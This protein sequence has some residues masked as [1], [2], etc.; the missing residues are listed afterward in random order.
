MPPGSVYLYVVNTS[1]T[2]VPDAP[3]NLVATAG[4]GKITLNW[5]A[6]AG[7]T[8]YNLYRGTV[9]SGE[10]LTPY[11]TGLTATTYA[12]TAIASE[13]AYYYQVSAV[14]AIGEGI[15]SNEAT[16]TLHD[17]PTNLVA[18]PADAQIALTWNP[19]V[20]IVDTYN[21]YRAP[22]NGYGGSG[23]YGQIASGVT[24]TCVYVDSIADERHDCTFTS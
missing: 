1:G 16:A 19:P 17:P 14:N 12:D 13:Q 15:R 6:T 22:D 21:V 20:G 7:A 24:T 8:T 11:K 9:G 4:N 3:A 5:S 23:T 10:G 18:I 2:P